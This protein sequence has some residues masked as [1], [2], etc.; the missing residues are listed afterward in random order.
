MKC[1]AVRMKEFDDQNFQ[2]DGTMLW[3]EVVICSTAEQAYR[4]CEFFNSE[5]FK[6]D[7]ETWQEEEPDLTVDVAQQRWLEQDFAIY[8]VEEVPALHK[9]EHLYRISQSLSA[10]SDLFE[11][12][13]YV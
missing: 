1:F 4:L 2:E 12:L 10:C 8:V 3:P 7:W 9:Y 13:L 5:S 6:V 11:D